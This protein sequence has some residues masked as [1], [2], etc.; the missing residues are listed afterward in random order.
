MYFS[1]FMQNYDPE[2]LEKNE[3][4][5]KKQEI[6]RRIN[7]SNRNKNYDFE[8]EIEKDTDDFDIGM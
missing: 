4:I 7:L 3:K 5:N 1:Q 2:Q 6:N 8:E